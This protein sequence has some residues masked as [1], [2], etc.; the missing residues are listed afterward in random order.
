MS[1]R[2]KLTE[3]FINELFKAM[4]TNKTVLKVCV[5]HFKYNFVPKELKNYKLIYKSAMDSYNASGIFPS[6]GVISQ[7][8]ENIPDVQ[9]ALSAINNTKLP[10]TEIILNQIESYIKDSEFT[11]LFDNI[12]E[13][14]SSGE[15]DSAIEKM[16]EESQRISN[17]SVR[18][19][20]GQFFKIFEDFRNGIEEEEEDSESQTGKDKMPFFIDPIDILLDGGMDSGESAL[21]ILRSGEG[22]STALRHTC[23]NAAIMGYDVLHFQLEGGIKPVR[24]K[25]NQ[26][27]TKVP[28]KDL[29]RGD[30]SSANNKKIDKILKDMEQKGRDLSI[31]AFPKFGEATV[32]ELRERILEYEKINGKFP[33]LIAVDSLN[34]CATGINRKIDQDPSFKKEKM[35]KV[36]ELLTDIATEFNTRVIT[37]TQSRDVPKDKYDDV[38]FVL[39]RNYTE[40]DRT[41]IQPFAYVFTFNR[42]NHETMEN[43][44][45]VYIDKLRH[46]SPK[47]RTYPIPTSYDNG[48]FFDSSMWNKKYA[49]KQ[50]I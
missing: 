29:K 8:Y 39:D 43:R 19:D 45:R 9:E 32:E 6:I 5:N 4:F 14:Y 46:Y 20:S 37:V 12:Y 28:Y 10:E 30:I 40:G 34:L 23:F 24:R 31:Y 3:L 36:A 21:W 1:E 49:T 38:D 27:W 7:R 42:T 22:K 25:Y 17:I 2:V 47:E 44:G 13:M 16:S 18:N 11:L 15:K 33:D 26:M 50:E 35:K 48:G 41:L